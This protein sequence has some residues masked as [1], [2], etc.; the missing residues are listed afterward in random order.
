MKLKK[1]EN[2]RWDEIVRIAYTQ[3]VIIARVETVDGEV[4]SIRQSAEADSKLSVIYDLL[5]I[6]PKPPGERKSIL[7]P[8]QIL[9]QLL[10]FELFSK[11]FCLNIS[12]LGFEIV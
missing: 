1:H 4:I 2:V 3:V 5:C 7:H 10:P 6:N 8:N 9:T 11:K 12:E